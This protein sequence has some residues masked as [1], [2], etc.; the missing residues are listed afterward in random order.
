[1]GGDKRST[2]I[3]VTKRTGNITT[4]VPKIITETTNNYNL[5]FTK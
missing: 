5:I 3:P 2:G 4:V 1:M